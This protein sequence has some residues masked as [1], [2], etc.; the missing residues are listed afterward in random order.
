[1]NSIQ[2]LANPTFTVVHPVIT[3]LS[4][5]AAQ[6]LDLITLNGSGFGANQDSSS[7]SINGAAGS[8]YS[9]SDTAI[10]VAIVPGTT[11]GPVTVTEDGV[12]SN[13]VQFTVL[14]GLTITSISPSS[15]MIGST[16]TIAG[17]GFGPTQ[18]NSVA[19]FDGVPATITNWGDTS[20]TAVVPAGAA[21]GPVTVAVG[22][23]AALGP[24]FT[25]TG[26]VT[27]TDS[28]GH[29]STYASVLAGGKWYVNNAQGSGCSSCTVR[30]ID[31]EPIRQ[32]RKRNPTTDELGRVTSYT[33]DTS[34]DVAT[35]TQPSVTGGTPRT[36]Y[37]Y[38][39]F[40]EVLTMTDPLGHV[41]TNTYDSHGNLLAVTTPAPNGSTAASVTQFAYNSLGEL[42]Q[43]T[44]PLESRHETYVH[45][46]GLIA[47][48]TDPQKNVTTY[49]YDSRGNRTSITDALSHQ[50]TLCLR[51]R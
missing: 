3:S 36:T 29:Q 33:Y 1:M 31:S 41:T 25:L 14:E 9:W 18:S 43:I 5:P 48:I 15:G 38:N 28:L 2:S 32:F 22:G 35:I 12:V 40:G 34:N 37:T 10:Q 24:T 16:V 6:I 46:S 44:D 27:L 50:T 4:P 21:T 19:T 8:V 30:G 26:S 39:S 17:T 20:I 51:H 11:S 42:T 49:R 7:V 23:T 13:S 45:A 47:T